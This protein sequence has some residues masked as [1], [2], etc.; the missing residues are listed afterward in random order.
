MTLLDTIVAHQIY[1][2]IKRTRSQ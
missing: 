2:L 1:Q